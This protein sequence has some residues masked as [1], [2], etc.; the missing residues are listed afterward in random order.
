M[1]G[2]MDRSHVRSGKYHLPVGV[3]RLGAAALVGVLPHSPPICHGEYDGLGRH[4]L[5]YESLLLLV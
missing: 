1:S 4:E 2:G 5:L 3:G